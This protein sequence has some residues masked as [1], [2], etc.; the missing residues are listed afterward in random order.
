MG[1][2][3]IRFEDS[4]DPRRDHIRNKV[5]ESSYAFVRPNVRCSNELTVKIAGARRGIR[6]RSFHETRTRKVR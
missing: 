1:I 3:C 5:S 4:L 6:S 2:T